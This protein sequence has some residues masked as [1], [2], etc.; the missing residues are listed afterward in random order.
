MQIWKLVYIVCLTVLALGFIAALSNPVLYGDP[1]IKSLLIA[2]ASASV[3]ALLGGHLFIS[4]D[5]GNTKKKLPHEDDDRNQINP[6]QYEA[7]YPPSESGKREY[8]PDD[9]SEEHR[10]QRN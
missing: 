5:R 10:N 6:Y 8:G 7:E 4:I 2:G 1:F 9:Q 3:V